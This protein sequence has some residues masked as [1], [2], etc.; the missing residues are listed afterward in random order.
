V[1]APVTLPIGGGV[2]EQRRSPKPL[3][4]RRFIGV[5]DLMVDFAFCKCV[6]IPMSIARRKDGFRSLLRKSAFSSTMTHIRRIWVQRNH[7]Y[8]CKDVCA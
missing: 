7:T 4:A 2:D 3:P 6:L 5:S 1:Q 8:Q